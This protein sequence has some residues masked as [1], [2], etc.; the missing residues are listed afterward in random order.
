[1]SK[2]G[3]HSHANLF[4]AIDFLVK[5]FEEPKTTT[6]LCGEDIP[7]YVLTWKDME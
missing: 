4:Q 7:Q 5:R 2:K 6:Y 3:D 1:M